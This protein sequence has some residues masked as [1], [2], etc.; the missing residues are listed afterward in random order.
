MSN[1]FINQGSSRGN[2]SELIDLCVLTVDEVAAVSGAV[3]FPQWNWGAMTTQ[4]LK[5]GVGG[6]AIGGFGSMAMGNPATTNAVING[7]SM[8]LP[9]AW[10]ARNTPR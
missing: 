8:G 5:W 3:N 4:G 1:H 2:S 10:A 6:M 9:A 7:L